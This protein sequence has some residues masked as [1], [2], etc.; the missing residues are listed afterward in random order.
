MYFTPKP[1]SLTILILVWQLTSADGDDCSNDGP[2]YMCWGLNLHVPIILW[3][4]H[5]EASVQL[6]MLVS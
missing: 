5:I 2:Q 1:I 6:A 3:E 4:I